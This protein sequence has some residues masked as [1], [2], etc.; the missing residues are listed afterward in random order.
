M[1]MRF[2]VLLAAIHGLIATGASALGSHFLAPYLAAGGAGLFSQAAT[3]QFFHALAMLGTA[4][5]AFRTEG[6][7]PGRAAFAF[8]I[9]TVLF[10]GTLY[11]RALM[12]PG[13]LGPFHWLTPIG[14]LCLMAGWVMLAMAALEMRE[15]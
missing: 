13:S 8:F 5:V 7:M 15:K 12:G 3:Y 9:G 11:M 4:F 10:S 2:I 6:E 14:G 1:E